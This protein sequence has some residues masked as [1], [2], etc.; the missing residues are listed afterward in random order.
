MTGT[1]TARNAATPAVIEGWK[2]LG[3]GVY[4]RHPYR[5][6]A[7][8]FPEGWRLNVYHCG[9]HIG[10]AVTL[11]DAQWLAYEHEVVA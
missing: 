9:K 11:E 10:R 1:S 7:C 3:K 5:L 6:Q 4:S 2:Q 8:Q